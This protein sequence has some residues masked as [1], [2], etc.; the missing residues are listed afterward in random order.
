MKGQRSDQTFLIIKLRGVF[1]RLNLNSESI[2]AK[3]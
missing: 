2:R 1:L 3:Y